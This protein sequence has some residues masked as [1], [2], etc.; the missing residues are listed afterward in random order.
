M[1]TRLKKLRKS[2]N[3]NGEEFGNILGVTKAAISKM[4]TGAVGITEQTI[5]SICREFNVNEQWLRN[6]D[7]DMFNSI[8]EDEELKNL[9]DNLF[10]NDRYSKLKRL[11][12]KHLLTL[13][14]EELQKFEDDIL[15]YSKESQQ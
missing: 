11:L 15:N 9:V 5:K 12:A 7:G 3:L 4:E 1:N 13:S 10:K 6:G 2:L 14:D 8:S